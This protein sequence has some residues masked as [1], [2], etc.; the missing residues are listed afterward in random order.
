VGVIEAM[1]ESRVVR[2]GPA[3][4]DPSRQVATFD[5][6]KVRALAV[7]RESQLQTFLW[8]IGAWNYEN[9]VP[10]TRVSPAYCDIGVAR[11]VVNAE[12]TWICMA[13][14]DGR[15]L[16][17]L[18][19]DAWSQQW[20]YA[21]TNGAYAILRSP[22]WNGEQIAFV[23]TMTMVG[24]TSEWRMTWSRNGPDRF[25]FVNEERTSDGRWAN[26]DEWRYQR[27]T[28]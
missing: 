26:V 21:L 11:F 28:D 2:M 15:Q 10:A 27:K 13:T 22:G 12:A 4:H 18:T 6:L 7:L 23:G 9:S 1:F 8:L 14:P 19:F 20:I 25:G 24:V 16:P 5:P 3:R 17:L